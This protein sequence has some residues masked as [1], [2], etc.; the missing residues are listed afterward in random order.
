MK[1]R[2]RVFAVLQ[3]QRP[4]RV[5]R[6]EIWID[7]LL[8]ELGPYDPASA[9]AGLGQDCVM[10]PTHI[11]PESNAWRNGVDEWGRVWQD[12]TYVDGVIDTVADL[13]RYSPPLSYVEKLYD[14]CQTR[15]VRERYPD[16]CL[17]FGTHIGPFTAGYMAMGFQRFFLRLVEDP[18][19]VHRLLEARTEWCIAMYQKAVGLGAEVLVLGD[20]AGHGEGSMIS[21]RMWREFILPYHRRIVDALAV[22]VIWHSDGNVRPLLSMAVEAGFVGFH[23]LDPLAGMDLAEI[24]WEFGQNL[25]LVGNVDVRT[26]CGSDLDAVRREVDR[27]IEQGAP[28]GGYMIATCNSI[29]EGMNP[30]AVAEMFRYEGEVGFYI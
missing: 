23:G 11:P 3:H 16:H 25:V 13:E 19:F 14:D 24:K 12:G 15:Q 7:A 26:L 10:L 20:D 2:E 28:D 21:P 6:F 22:P 18:A 4:D 5:P 29:F 30:A 27:C 9:Y 8:D 17:I 1:P